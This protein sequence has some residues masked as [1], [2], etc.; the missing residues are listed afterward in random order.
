APE[1][2][3]LAQTGCHATAASETGRISRNNRHRLRPIPIPGDGCANVHWGILHHLAKHI[4][5]A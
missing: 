1:P 5:G 3:A 2:N 4:P